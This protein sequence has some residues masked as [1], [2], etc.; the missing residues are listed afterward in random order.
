MNQTL[1]II[2]IFTLI[3]FVNA[4]FAT[5]VQAQNTPLS[6]MPLGDSGTAGTDYYTVTAGGYRD[7][8][9]HDLV[10][11]GITN[12]TF[13]GA[14]NDTNLFGSAS[15]TLIEANQTSNNGYGGYQIIDISNNLDGVA[16]PVGGGAGNQGGYW[17][18]GGGGTGRGP[19]YPN[20]ML[21]EAGANDIIQGAS[22]S[23]VE[24][25]LANLV[26]KIHRLSP[27]TIIFVAGIYPFDYAINSAQNTTIQAYDAYIKNTLV[28]ANSFTYYVDNY[29]AFLNP[30]GTVNSLLLGA[31]D[32][33]PTRYGYPVWAENWAQAI[34]TYIASHS[35]TYG[36]YMPS[37]PASYNLSVGNGIAQNT[38]TGSGS[39]PA[40]SII[41][42]NST[43]APGGEQFGSWSTTSATT[44]LDNPYWQIST[45]VM[46]A[47]NTTV[48]ANYTASGS[49]ITPNGTYDIVA[50][51]DEYQMGFSTG[52]NG[53][54]MGTTGTAS[55]SLAQEQTYT[56][57]TT[58]QWSLNN[59]GNN[60]VE[61]AVSG[62]A[63]SVVGASTAVNA[64]LDIATYTGAT[65]QQWTITPNLGTT[66]LVNVNSGMAACYG[67]SSSSGTQLTQYTA[68]YQVY[69][70]W[71]LYPAAGTTPPPA[72]TN[73]TATASSGKVTLGWSASSGATSYN[74]YRGTTGGGEPNMAIV[75]ANVTTT[76]YTDTALTGP[77][78]TPTALTATPSG[79]DQV[80]LTWTPNS[81]TTYY[82]E[83]VAV[84]SS[85]AASGGSNDASAAP[86]GGAALTG[87][88]IYR[89]TDS[90]EHDAV[91]VAL[92]GTSP[93]F[94]DTGL[95][96]GQI[97][98]Y[99]VT[100]LS[101]TGVSNASNQ[102]SAT[103]SGSGASPVITSST[104]ASGSV[105]SAFSYQITASNSP[106][107]FS[108][109]GLPS[110]LSVNTTTGAIT[111][112]PTATGTSTVTIGAT[113]ANGTGSAPLT[114]TI[115]AGSAPV[116][117]SSTSASGAVGSA[118]SYQIT[119]SN[120][121]TSYS[122]TGLPSGLS[123]STTTGAI[124]GTPAASGTSSV[125]IGATNSIGTGTATL[126]LTISV[127]G[128][129]V[130]TSSTSASGTVGT[131]FSYQITASNSPTSY[132]A[133]GLPAG[134]SVSTTTG[135][136]TGTPTASGTS[137]VTI[138]A[139]N[140][141]GTGTATLTL[142]VSSAGA[143]IAWGTPS[144]MS[145]DTDVVTNGTAFDAVT[146]YS[147]ATAVNGVTFNP[148]STSVSGG[149]ED[150]SGD[151]AITGYTGFP[152]PP[153]GSYTA[154]AGGSTN[155]NNVVS[156]LV[157]SQG[158]VGTGPTITLSN[159]TSGHTYQV[160]VWAFDGKLSDNGLVTTQLSGA[161]APNGLINGAYSATAP[162]VGQFVK[163]TFTAT[164][165]SKTFQALQTQSFSVI[166]DIAV[167]D[168]TSAGS[169]PVITS[170]TS[171]SGTAGTA[172]SYQITASNTPTS[173]SATG[174]PAGLSVS[175]TTGAI[176]GTPSVSG[177]TSVTIGA[178]NAYGTGT[179]TLTVTIAAA[180]SAPVITSSTSASGTVGAVFSYQ[181]TASNTPTS[182]SATGLPAGLSVSTSTG[183]I[184][185]TPT[186][187]GTTSVTIG[188]TNAYGTGTATLT[189][190]VSAA[191]SNIT[192]GTATNMS[193]DTD[194][195]TNGTAFDA[196]TFYSTATAV[197]GVTF[198][199]LSTSLS[200]GLEDASGDIAITGYTGF[201]LAPGGS[202]TT[203]AGGSA[204]YN[205]AVSTLIF[206][207]G[208]VGTGM[209]VTLSN[210][211]SGHTYQVE[212]WAFDGKLSD[213]GQV[214]T[215]LSGA[216]APNGLING[217]NSA[218]APAIGQFVKGTF[219][220]SGSTKSFQALQTQ[221]FSV[222]NNVSVRDITP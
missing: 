185:G 94:T 72:P 200:N 101:V 27:S 149:V 177:T 57:A 174:L 36:Q 51:S 114:L 93:S 214:T 210:L 96:S 132:S 209:T 30:D 139:T 148:L 14:N 206:S 25:S 113:N 167:R 62:N 91:L 201:P 98:Y 128:A 40:G 218:T 211:V 131:A 154:F 73:L 127:A 52:P 103:A 92:N 198:N 178:T 119:A 133:S 87:F 187:S 11:S 71:A 205:N 29:S 188:A 60:T 32:V 160:E 5:S 31:D 165:S 166:N 170:S 141:T 182:Y 115:S 135:A 12:F 84:N 54:S 66:E 122:A 191:S 67:Y 18:T 143:S 49:S 83:V 138:G 108:A 158:G 142:T 123:V 189:L 181:I 124:T 179:A 216:T 194:V 145:T 207:Q 144:I 102:S 53:L 146:F 89:G 79:N 106:T 75:A 147:T 48:T 105:G 76:S 120:S 99:F 100:A 111:G 104:S 168:V 61:L 74:V 28:P 125:T 65:S 6:I 193:T 39:F 7:P 203:Y 116:I 68:G 37:S 80:A 163:G 157:F 215:Q 64:N 202:Y 33:H 219:V 95:T 118:F 46:P 136:I 196:V 190:T 35:S 97:Y 180:G 184:T 34:R 213:N 153:G 90:N 150:A 77:P 16:N 197:N 140:S 59:L 13:V 88:D 45:F 159:L 4:L 55:G 86:T 78:P 175:T 43:A 8:L 41:T 9:Y 21:L 164:S 155:Y 109:S 26:A 81:T 50:G 204:N 63:L 199:P 20:F 69:Q 217:A 58:Q 3:A 15:R 134:L 221:N 19:D 156:T 222:I 44:S 121:P 42:V 117:T 169:A 195:A 107:S 151:I 162:A 85:G 176:T 208:G 183:A 112:T 10:A 161:T 173:Y 70:M 82:Y 38:G 137:S 212:V 56:G 192:W 1:K 129:P 110:G 171:A 126:T 130:I 186:A 2:G 152:L 172:F 22:A 23:T 24:T 17:L 220:A 47:A